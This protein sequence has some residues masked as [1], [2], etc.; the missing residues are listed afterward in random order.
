MHRRTSTVLLAVLGT[1]AGCSGHPPDVGRSTLS[2]N[3]TWEVEQGSL[4]ETPPSSYGHSTSVPGLL[5]TA[6]PPFDEIG[7]QSD[8]R[9]AFW[10]RRTFTTEAPHHVALLRF[11][12][13]KYGL[14]VWLD[15]ELLGDHHGA[16]TGATFD[17]TGKVQAGATHTIV[18]RLGAWRDGVPAEVP[19]GQDAEKLRWIPGLYD[20]VELIL[21]GSPHVSNTQLLVESLEQSR[22]LLRT[23]LTN[24]HGR[25][26][27]AQVRT[28]I[29]EWESG[30]EASDEIIDEVAL[31]PDVTA[32]LEQSIRLHAA[33]LWSPEDPFLYVARTDVFV[34]GALRDSHETRFGVRTTDWRADGPDGP[35]FYLNGARYGLRG[36]NITL[37]RFFEDDE[38][39][40][41]PWDEAWVRKLL[42]THPKDLHWNTARM[43]IGRA[44][45]MWYRVADEVGL[46]LAD[47]FMMWT[48]I[49]DSDDTWSVDLMADE[50]AAWM[51]EAWN[52]PSIAWWDG[53]NETADERVNTAIDAVRGMDPS[54]DWES[55][56]FNPPNAE[57]DPIEDHPY[58]FFPNLPSDIDALDD[59]DGQPPQGG[60]PTIS[61]LTWEAPSH[62]YVLNEYGWLWL[63][64]D[65]TPT[66]LSEGVWDHLIGAGPHSAAVYREA[67]AYLVAG[68]TG[69]WR[70][71][72]GYA[73]VLH[74]THLGYSREGGAT[75]DNWID[76]ANLTLEPRWERYA[77]AAF[78]P[79]AAYIDTWNT[80]WTA[81]ETVDVPVRLVNDEAVAVSGVLLLRAV[82]ETGTV[83]YESEPHAVSVDAWATTER[84]VPLVVPTQT[85]PWVLDAVL[86]PEGER[87]SSWSRRKVGFANYG[88]EGPPL[89]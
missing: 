44:P 18:A 42:G 37:H 38:A 84:E 20:D 1:L 23:W 73:G 69:F 22:V 74:F 47:E 34:E 13:A 68:L 81:G 15:G 31:G 82:S 27:T 14:T 43:T 85:G 61:V 8:A 78:A 10:L 9:E 63:D 32:A 51:A 12:K 79:T 3:G 33:R 11:H 60:V 77:A 75:S 86:T 83:L 65:G 62:P 5:T 72:G 70:S 30:A 4:G 64:R 2:L 54:R 67:Y 59:N 89:P 87:P 25:R 21:S 28:V 49:D 50:Y 48:F 55:G 80:D 71:H 76:V 41:L 7:V 56:G 19:I 29:Y 16:F 6:S 36:T 46:L 24:Q 53:A 52:H 26:E 57:G 45:R 66:A 40:T 17:V 35:G 39:G 58:V 88:I